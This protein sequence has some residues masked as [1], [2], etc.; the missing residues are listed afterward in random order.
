MHAHKEKIFIAW[1]NTLYI[2]F[3]QLPIRTDY[4]EGA[5]SSPVGYIEGLYIEPGHRR[6]GVAQA[7]IKKTKIWTREKNGSE[8]ASD[9][10]LLNTGSIEF[11][12]AMG[13]REINRIVCFTKDIC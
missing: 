12:H 11:H 10:E 13:F 4:V 7:L 5:S 9:A 6:K 1:Q 3:I 8:I 2:G